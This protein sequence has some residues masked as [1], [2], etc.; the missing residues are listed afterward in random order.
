[1]RLIDRALAL[2]LGLLV[3][4]AA[5]AQSY[6]ERPVTMVVPFTAGGAGDILSRLL[7][8]RLEQ[9]WGKPLIVDNK[10][11]AGGVIGAQAAARAAPDGYT[12]LIGQSGVLAVNVT[13]YKSLSYDPVAD[14]TPLAL[15]A[16]TPFTLVVNPSLPIHSVAEMISYVKARPGQISYATSGPGVPHHLFAELLKTL[17]GIQMSPVAYRGSA[18]ALTDVVAGHVPLM[19]VD[20]GPALAMIREGKVRALGVSTGTRIAAIADVPTIA[21]AGV[22]GFDA[23]SWQ[24]ITAPA[25]TPSAIIDKL[26]GDL[27]AVLAMSE[28]KEQILA[29]GMLPM[30]SRSVAA[31]QDFIKSEITRWGKVVRQAGI[32][33][34][35]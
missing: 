9:R 13:L 15:V 26:H 1:M 11:G 17:T 29:A 22:P 32:A 18:P 20:L 12:L 34:S 33:G 7:G 6:P 16:Q 27:A 10:P 25:K 31:L 35:Q 21:E 23:A 14:F 8:P 30:P 28:V 3:A 24:M 2:L 19:F 4:G 5:A